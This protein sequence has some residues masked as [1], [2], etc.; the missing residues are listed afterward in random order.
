MKKTIGISEETYKPTLAE[1][2]LDRRNEMKARGTLLM[3]LSNKDQLKFHSYQDAKL[4]IEAIAKSTNEADITASGVSTAHTQEDLEQIDPDDLEEIDIHWEMAML[5]IR[6]RRELHAPKHD[7]RII[8]EHFESV[9]V[10]VISNIAPSDVKT[11]KTIDVNHKGVF[12]TEEPKLIMKNKFSPLI[13]E[14]WHSDG[15]RNK[16]YLTDF[17]AYDG[18]F[19]SLEME[20]VEFLL[21]QVLVRVP[22]KDNIYSVDLKSVVPTR[23]LTCLFAKATLD[24][25][26]L[27]HRRLGA[28]VIKP[29]NN[30]PYELIRGRPPLIDF[31]KPFGCLVTILNT[32]DNLGKFEGKADDGYFFGYSV[33]AL[34]DEFESFR[35]NGNELIQDYFVR[36]HKLVNDMKVTQLDIPT[37]QLNIKF[38]NNLPSYWGKYV[39]HA[40]NNMNMSTVMYVE[41]FTHLRT[42]EEHAL[43]SLK[44]NEQSSAVVD[45]LAYLAKTTPT[46]STASPV[47]VP[48]PQSSGDSHN[49][50]MLATINQIA[51]LLSGLQKQF[52][53]TNNQLR[54]SSNPKTHAT[55]HDGQIVT[56]RVQRR[57]LGKMRTKAFMANLSSIGGTNGLSSSLINEEMQ[58]EE[59]LNSEVDSVLDD[60]M[61]TY[62][63]YQNDSGVEAVLT[64]VSAD[65]ADKQSMI[66]VLQRMHTKIAGYVRVND[67]HKL[68]NATLTAELE[69]CKIDM[70]ALKRN[71]VKHDLDMAIV[72]RNKRNAELEEENVMLK[73]TLKSK[74]VSIEN[75]QQESKQVLSEKETLE[76]KY[77]E[78]IVVL[79]NANKLKEQLQGRDDSLRNLQAQNDIM[80]LLN[81]GSTDDSCNK[82]A[83]E[84][85]LTQLKDT[86]TSLKI[87]FDG[88]K[89]T[90]PN[91]NRCYEELS[92]A[93]T[94]LRTTSLEKIA[95]QKAEIA[96]LNAK[97]VGNKTSE[98]TKPTNPKETPK[99]SPR[100]TKKPVAPLLKKPN[101]NVPLS[102]RLK[103]ATGAS[104]PASKSNAWIYRKLPAKSAKGEKVLSEK[105]TLEDKYLEEIV[106][107]T[108]ANKVRLNP[109][110]PPTRVHDSEE[111]LVHA[112]VCK[113]KMAERPG[114]ALPINYAKL[115]ALY[116]QFVPQNGIV[117]R[118]EVK[119]FERIFDE[120]DA[121]YERILLEKKNMQI[122]K[123]NLL[124]TNECLI[125]NSIAN[126]IRSIALAYDLV[127]PPSSD[128]SHCMLEELRTTCDREHP[129]KSLNLKLRF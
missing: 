1:E 122:E 84:T 16:C 31:L 114:H 89:V 14:D 22:R 48:T 29:H 59:H 46:H 23:D 75:L 95:A 97:T 27:W 76:D 9:S 54:T 38:A 111:S 86:V 128:S 39:T 3:A 20:K 126:D 80:S 120:L 51:N 58:Q 43:K 21:L 79:T 100:F 83:L 41:L 125:A 47:T 72:E 50:A 74:V 98:T 30:T 92:K 33:E 112:E 53:P 2:K 34:F 36:F 90:N 73:S 106:V 18:G 7:L 60:N 17:E 88:Y 127:V 35:A 96:T 24:E 113:I 55:V 42:Y 107:L 49:D 64:V 8:D 5:T 109:N 116:D 115:N 99:P 37:H 13:I 103:S 4:L 65:E 25:S 87:Q 101:V 45:P 118:T 81:V 91:L 69:W 94:H 26:N 124:I 67:E 93:N 105:E 102:T 78:E 82:Q 129:P 119:E 15:E 110:H 28:L 32:R 85:Q 63:E 52:P 10:D 12:K 121:E 71:K 66:A 123:K 108:N 104:K 57:A 70:Q 62:D 77:L 6:D 68:D 56:E 11:V 61:I 19:V 44:K 40:K 117:P